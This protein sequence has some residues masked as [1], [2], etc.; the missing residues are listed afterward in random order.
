MARF[1]RLGNLTLIKEAPPRHNFDRVVPRISTVGRRKLGYIEQT[2]GHRERLIYKA[3]FHWLHYAVAWIEL[4][5]ILL[6]A[7]LIVFFTPTAWL[8][9]VFLL[10]CMVALLLLVRRMIP[11]WTTEIGVTDNR[12][13]V[14]RGWLAR[15]T[16][17]LQLR[18][19][20]QVNL[21]QGVVGRLLGYGQVDVHG[22]GVDNLFIPAIADPLSFVRAIEDATSNSKVTPSSA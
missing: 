14:K 5:L 17:E 20:E 22:T 11:I 19:I 2:L 12:L 3:H 13:I 9:Y 4:V 7:A 10:G 8:E 16:D 1:V 21:R 18:S 15:S 6:L